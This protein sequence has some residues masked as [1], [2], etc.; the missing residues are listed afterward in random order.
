MALYAFS[1]ILKDESELT[2]DLAEA[3]AAA[4]CDDGAS[5]SSEGV[6][7]VDFDRDADS[8]EHA[9]RSAVADVQKAGYRVARVEIE[10]DA[11]AETRVKP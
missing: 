7:S 1:V 3:L 9:I 10:A 6:V 11:L 8:L 5:R 2:E 4:G